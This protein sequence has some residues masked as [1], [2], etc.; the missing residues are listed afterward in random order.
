MPELESN[1]EAGPRLSGQIE[2][3]RKEAQSLLNQGGEQAQY[4]FK[5]SV[6]LGRDNL[7]D[8]LDFVKFVQAVANAELKTDRCIVIGGDPREKKFFPVTNLEEFDAAN[9][10]KILGSYL[11]PLP[12][13]QS[14][15]LTTEQGIPFVLIVLEQNQPRPIVVIRQ[16]H[17]E[18]GK[19]RLEEGDIWVKKNTNTVR[20][21]KADID[22][23]YKQRSEEEAE[24]RARQRVAHF[25]ELDSLS[26]S[27]TAT[28]TTSIPTFSILVGPRNEFRTFI[29]ELIG[30][31]DRLRF[32]IL[33]E[34]CR[35]TIVEAWDNVDVPGTMSDVEQFFKGLDDLH[36]NQYLPALD[37]LIDAGLLII[38]HN[39]D[40]K[41]LEAVTDL[42][43]ESFDA[44][45][46]LVRFQMYSGGKQDKFPSHWWRPSLE[47]YIGIRAIA[48]YAVLRKRLLF[49]GAILPHIVVRVT[50]NRM[51]SN[52]KTPIVFWP[53]AA[54]PFVAGELAEG[55]A[56]YFWGERVASS[57]GTYFGTLSKFVES[58]SQLELLLEFNSYLGTNQIQNPQLQDWVRNKNEAGITFE[59]APDLYAQDLQATVP[60]AESLYDI[61]GSGDVFP[62][63]LTVDPQLPLVAFGNLKGVQRLEL[64]GGF[65]HRLKAWQSQYRHQAFH[66]FG[67]MWNWE[68]RLKACAQVFADREKAKHTNTTQ[69]K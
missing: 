66:A 47:L 56:Q 24:G 34:L 8:R 20:A 43:V 17:T 2:T 19:A 36:A 32:N 27:P 3:H 15:R 46:R 52:L 16:G 50:V 7:D 23:M 13:F 26:R 62:A 53:F 68:G 6:A 21:K 67:F 65:L 69:T 64:Y 4:E 38:K 40:P 48:S 61:L 11:D 59:Y 28:K 14:Y 9:L 55:R 41:W 57:W 10:S 37:S 31:N 44:C 63:F 30:T 42:L 12:L 49:L 5:R 22:L 35:E 45:H 39:A 33:L 25:I 18:R 60:M 51:Y 29:A 58:S 54:L 1:K